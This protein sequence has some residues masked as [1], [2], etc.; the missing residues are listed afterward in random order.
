MPLTA[1]RLYFRRWTLAGGL[2]Q[3]GWGPG[4][5][6]NGLHALGWKLVHQASREASGQARILMG[7]SGMSL[8][9]A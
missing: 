8:L 4:S 1:N 2:A 9:F 5:G 3:A 6:W 7:M